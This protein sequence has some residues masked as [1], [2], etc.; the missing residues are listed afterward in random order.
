MFKLKQVGGLVVCLLLGMI[1]Y[2]QQLRLGKNPYALQKSAILELESDNQGLLFP[3]ITDTLQINAL[4]PPDGMV[5][6]HQPTHQLM[7][8]SQ[9]AWK[10]LPVTL[11]RLQDVTINTPLN[12]QVL[13]Y[14]GSRWI[15][16]TLPAYLTS[17]DTS[18][19]ASFHLKVKSLFSAGSGLNYNST[20]GRFTNAGVL[21]LNGSTGAL[22]LDTGYI[23]NFH[24]KSKS[25]LSAGSGIGY[26]ATTGIISNSGVLSVNGNTGALTID[27]GYINNF[28]VKV[29]NLLS[30]GSGISYNAT[31]GIISSTI[32][33]GDYWNLAGNSN[34]VAGTSFLG[35]T[36]DKPLQFRSNNNLYA[37]LGSRQTLGLVQSSYA[38]YTDGAEQVTHLRSA[39]QFYAPGASFYKPKMFV[40]ANG[41]FRMKGS[42]AGTDFFEFGATGTAN[43]GGFEFIVGDDGNEPIVFKSQ[44]YING[45]SEIMRL[46]NGRA[47]IGSSTFDATNPEKL[48]VDAGNTT[49]FNVISG[50]GSIDNYLQLNIQNR[51]NG[52]TASS[53]IV[54][55]ADNGTES[56]NYVDLGIN[57]SG[58]TNTSYP[59]LSGINNAY[60]YSTGSDF[61]IGNATASRNLRFFTGGYATANERLRIDG[62]G[63]VGIGTQAPTSLLHV[64]SGT[65]DVSG[66]RLENLTSSS[67]ST[68]GASTLG[69]DASGNVVKAKAPVYYSGGIGGSA[70]VDGIT[71]VWVAEIANNNTGIQTIT[72]PANIGF[73]SIVA[74][75]L[76]AKGGSDVESAPIATVAS[77]TTTT[78]T[79]RVVESKATT[80]VI[81]GTAEGLL[82]HT[83]T[84]TRIY[85]RVEGN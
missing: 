12:G 60:L 61:V 10:A 71:K 57:S 24:L 35:T 48:L 47:A 77:N 26:N 17:V 22:T 19:I 33:G 82:A 41:N 68:S 28:H 75:T 66:V 20:T 53:D 6:Y 3:R 80:I 63:K 78:I 36:D 50:K 83:N 13:S 4:V 23:N 65:T 69:I 32:N 39:L 58:F 34:T 84:A 49:S 62:T 43:D 7:M 15:N 85:I 54:A 45:Q 72:I 37:E 8:R 44:H 79:I 9:G 5:I 27:T 29:K 21:S 38:D 2:S 55:T 70:T 46:Q 56:L 59:I 18:N 81:G 25:L 30:A 73:T 11:Q 74:I 16:S 40:D 76:T 51:S 14:N 1:G 67:A 31:T 42:S 52:A 64:K